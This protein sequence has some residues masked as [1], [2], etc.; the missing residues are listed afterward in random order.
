VCR[1]LIE[2]ELAHNIGESQ[3]RISG[4]GQELDNVEYPGSRRRRRSA[5]GLT[6][7]RRTS[8]SYTEHSR[9]YID[10]SRKLTRLTH[11]ALLC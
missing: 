1:R 8:Y 4:P 7:L 6:P 3:P 10:Y 11:C 9:L 2:I 5:N